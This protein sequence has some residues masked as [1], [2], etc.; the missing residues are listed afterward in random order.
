MDF[1][2]DATESITVVVDNPCP[3]RFSSPSLWLRYKRIIERKA[4]SDIPVTIFYTSSEQRSRRLEQQ[5]SGNSSW[6]VWVNDNRD[7]L[8]QFL[9]FERPKLN[10]NDINGFEELIGL[11][12]E[13]QDDTGALP[14]RG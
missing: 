6:D 7:K 4:R 14:K 11:L 3:A 2:E 12:K 5:F 8:N 10:S 13:V 1:L 9:K